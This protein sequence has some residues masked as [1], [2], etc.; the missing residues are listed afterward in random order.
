MTSVVMVLAE[1][2]KPVRVVQPTAGVAGVI[3]MGFVKLVKLIQAV[4]MIALQAGAAETVIVLM[5]KHMKTVLKIVRRMTQLLLVIREHVQMKVC[6]LYIV[7]P[8]VLPSQELVGMTRTVQ[9]LLQIV[10]I[11]QLVVCQ[12]TSLFLGDA[13]LQGLTVQALLI[14]DRLSV[15]LAETVI[16]IVQ[17]VILIV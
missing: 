9:I 13:A 1:G 5:M 17:I 15:L 6:I 11:H 14:V 2:M 4:L 10:L 3:M 8:P 12:D 7:S 16:Q